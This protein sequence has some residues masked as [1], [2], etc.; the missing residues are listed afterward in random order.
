MSSWLLGAAEPIRGLIVGQGIGLSVCCGRPTCSDPIHP[1]TAPGQWVLSD[2]VGGSLSTQ[3]S[4]CVCSLIPVHK[5]IQKGAGIF[6][7]EITERLIELMSKP[8]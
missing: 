1:R 5:C 2:E 7:A 6:Q 8:I 4:G 3:L